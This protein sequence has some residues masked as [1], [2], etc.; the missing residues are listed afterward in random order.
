MLDKIIKVKKLHTDAKLPQC[1][2]PGSDLEFDLFALENT[3]ISP[4]Q[5]TK[6][7][8]GIAV[9]LSGYGFLIHDRSSIAAKGIFT[10]GGVI[11]AG[12]RGEIVVL[13]STIF[14][15]SIKRG[16]KIAQMIP[17]A[18]SSLYLKKSKNYP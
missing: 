8:T 9:E 13:M 10:H 16:D 12:Y 1:S 6:V 2:N 4:H 14:A 18:R 7:R 5:L 11:D 17:V 15:H 3:V